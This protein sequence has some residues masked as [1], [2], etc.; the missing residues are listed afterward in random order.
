MIKRDSKSHRVQK[1][2][3]STL[4]LSPFVYCNFLSKY[5]KLFIN[6]FKNK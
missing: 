5:V 6:A 1:V 2:N 3:L 4:Q